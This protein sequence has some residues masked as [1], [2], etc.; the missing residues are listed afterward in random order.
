MQKLIVP[1]VIG[2]TF[3]VFG[4][5]CQTM[6]FVA[7]VNPIGVV[8]DLVSALS[9]LYLTFECG[10]RR[11]ERAARAALFRCVTAQPTGYAPCTSDSQNI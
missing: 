4:V 6:Y 7:G 1:A 5:L 8:N 10:R 3:G 2:V 9:L 11:G